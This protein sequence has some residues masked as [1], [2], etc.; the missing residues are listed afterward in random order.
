MP[1][2]TS[3]LPAA[4]NEGIASRV[5]LGHRPIVPLRALLAAALLALALG[6]VFTGSLA[7]RRSSVA[8][9]VRSGSVT[10]EGLLSLPL[11]AQGPV[12]GAMGA[13]N[14]YRVSASNGGFAAASPAQRLSVRFDRSG[15]SLS[16]GGTHVGLSLQA[17][18]YGATLSALGTVAPGAK[19]NRV[20]YARRGLSEWYANGPLG[21]EQ[22]FTIHSAPAGRQ[23]GPL[24]LSMALS[25]NARGWLAT[26]GQS[27]MLGPEGGPS[28]RYS[29]LQAIDAS[30]RTLH[31]W[32]GLH[33][34][35][36]LLR[37]DA[38]G[39]RYPVRIDPFIQQGEK[40][41]I[42]PGVGDSGFG[43]HVAVSSDGSTALISSPNDRNHGAVWVFVRS[44]SSWTQQGE[45]LVPTACPTSVSGFGESVALSAD[46]NTALIGV[47]N[48]CRVGQYV[49]ASLVFT[50]SGSTWTERAKLTGSGESGMGDFGSS[51]ALSANGRIA[52]VGAR[53][54]GNPDWKGAA[55][56]FTRSGE[57]W[58]QQGPKLTGSGL[59]EFGRGAALSASGDTA[60]VG[61]S[62]GA[63]VFARSG[64]EWTQQGEQLTGGPTVALSADGNTALT[65]I[66]DYYPY[67]GAA[68][69]FTRASSTWSE[70][71]L[72]TGGGLEGIGGFGSSVA[73]SAEGNTALVGGPQ[74]DPDVPNFNLG[75]AWVFTR[76][77]EAWAQQ[78]E[79]LTGDPEVAD[80]HGSVFFGASVALLSDGTAGL[81]GGPNDNGVGSVW[82]F[83][84]SA[85]APIVATNAVSSL[86]ATSATLDGVVNPNG[87]DVTDCYFEYGTRSSYGSRVPCTSLPGSGKS[88]VAV[89]AAVVGLRQYTT[90]HF[91]L[92][93]TNTSGANHGSERTFTTPPHP[94]E[95]G[96]C[97][98]VAKGVHGQFA[99][100]TC[101]TL[102]TEDKYG[103]EWLPGPG[104]K[105]RFTLLNKPLTQVLLETV[106]GPQI[107]CS[108]A[109]GSGEYTGAH[110]VGNVTI[111]FTGCGGYGGACS[112]AGAQEGV[113][114]TASLNGT[115][116]VLVLA[117]GPAKNIV[118]TDLAPPEGTTF[119]EAMCGL[120]PV[121]VR[122]SV[123]APVGRNAMK[124]TATIVYGQTRGKQKYQEFIGGQ[125]DV[126]ETVFGPEGYRQTGIKLTIIQTN[127][128]KVEVNSVF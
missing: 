47:P 71:A 58:T 95:Y 94:V 118:G 59:G 77:G 19:G 40:L 50:R 43:S 123:I 35:R 21:L 106:R 112:S 53:T 125:R 4:T 81:I 128:E 68:F 119:L 41:P 49:G 105:P 27:I 82:Q 11:T 67:G 13:D 78:G 121:S 124:G 15:V 3:P 108:G 115:L 45:K 29:G 37:V 111:A 6:A 80:Q 61:G 30:E 107:V 104:P 101:T 85:A 113:I 60:L 36:L 83:T 65:G 20:L 25:G 62:G 91:R 126:L 16:S 117:E 23:D 76:S 79:K 63:R 97:L 7:G 44:G 120:I 72:L 89:T 2:Q 18:G 55:W 14:P 93:A 110:T 24:T 116:G 109:F 88:P 127:E 84:Y 56:V 114:V 10:H 22:G 102:A 100:G 51:V 42:P 69:V 48:D 26:G 31:T 34:G 90:Y 1:T 54:D 33:N 98:K 70:Q 32:L 87:E 12:S 9:A 39:A 73:L 5:G 38:H 52:L 28:L 64:E 17:V 122:G 46:G 86:A 103:Y 92:F 66:P 75:A 74:D 96:R 57:E 8:P 99:T